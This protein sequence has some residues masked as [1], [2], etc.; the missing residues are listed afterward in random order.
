M[1]ALLTA[2]VVLAVGCATQ[3]SWV[4]VRST[5][6]NPLATT[7][8]LLSKEGPQESSR[9]AQLLR[10]YALEE[11]ASKDL[12]AAVQQLVLI[13]QAEANREIQYSIAELAYIAGKRNELLNRKAALSYYGTS[14]L[15]AYDYLFDDETTGALGSLS[16]NPY[17]PQ[18]REACDLYNQSLEATL[19]LVQA[20]G[21]LRPGRQTAVNTV[22]KQCSF[23]VELHSSGWHEEDFDSFK[24]VSDYQLAG[25]RNHYHT[26]GLG[27]PLIAQRRTHEGELGA[28]QFYPDKLTFP[29]TAFLRIEHTTPEQ[30]AAAQLQS[31]TGEKCT[32]RF[33]LELHDPLDRQTVAVGHREVALESDLSTPLAYFL[34]QPDF[35]IDKASTRGLLNPSE[36]ENL[37]G[38]YMLEPFD[39]HKMPVVM[40]HGLWSSPVTWMEM[41]NDLR[42]DPYVRQHYQFW[43]YLYPTGQP[44]W[45]SAA[46]MR[47]D[48][49]QA[50]QVVDPERQKPALDQTVLV[51]HSMGGLVSKLQS[52]DSGNRFWATLSDQDFKA[53]KADAQL[54][55]DL[56]NTF[57]FQPNP[58]VRRVVTIATPHSGSNFSNRFTRWA[59]NSL[60]RMPMK[61]VQGRQAI[62]ADNKDYFRPDAPLDIRTSLD[63]LSPS[64]ML[65][66]SLRE[67]EPGPWVTYHNIVGKQAPSGL[68]RWIGSEGDG[69]V[70][71]ESARLDGL[72]NV[73][74]QLVV[75]SDHQN[76]HR[77]PQSV[78][79]VRRILVQQLGELQQAPWARNDVMMATATSELEPT[80]TP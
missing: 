9:T 21:V 77:H 17:D 26:Y 53:L 33:V 58:A 65:L 37:Q 27:V 59:G 13:H 80:Q 78:L 19:R 42:S 73:K 30:P 12:P 47:R 72:P 63:S 15:H 31:P 5:P 71:L 41:F 51:G 74:S 35:E 48:L 69:V 32:S 34:N 54:R 38:L 25:L 23:E 28:E 43:F 70:S 4:T 8:Q 16:K 36:V 6:R 29:L 3:S 57:F 45:I 52:I 60:I 49:E 62:L 64:S 1:Y 18:F 44:F 79:E 22:G 75:E 10:R 76:V 20:D 56:S 66:T 61:L 40:V 68:G 39:P 24:F 7:L 14:I 50:R 55:D 2:H 46:E 67:A 11:T